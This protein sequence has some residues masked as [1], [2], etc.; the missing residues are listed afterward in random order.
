LR[1]EQLDRPLGLWTR[2]PRFSWQIASSTRG[3]V[4]RAYELE[5]RSVRTPE[6]VMRTGRIESRDSVLVAFDGFEADSATEYRWRVR[7]WV[8][9]ADEPT[10]WAGSTFE[11]ALLRAED[12]RARWIQ[13]RQTPVR[14]DGAA[15]FEELF[16]LRIDSPPEDRLLPAPYVRQR[17]RLDGTPVRARLAATA[18]GIYEAQINGAP[19]SDE[20]FAPGVESYDIHLSFQTYDVTDHVV[21]GDNVLGVVLS[22]G[23]FAGRVGIL[24]SSRGYGDTLK[25]LWQL[26]VDYADGRRATIVSDGTAVS[27]TDG[28][29][30]YADLAVGE[31]YD[32]RIAWDGWSTVAFDDSRWM[33]V[34][35]V[36]VDQPLVPFVGEPVR[37]VGEVPATQILHTPAGDTVVDFG[38]V[39]AGRVRFRVRGERGRIVRL[40][41]AEVRD[42]HGEYFQNIVGPNKDQTDVYVLSGHPDGE[43][44]EPSF[45]FHGFRYVR[46]TGFPESVTADDFT[47]VV[48]SSDLP[49]IGR[50]ETSDERLNRLHANV[51]WSQRANFL[52]IP[53]DCPQRERYGWTGDLQ[54]FA[55]AAATNMAVGPF[56]S[57]WLRIVR[58][59]QLPD[60]RIMNISPSPPQLDHLMDGPAPSYDDPI[61]LLASSAGWGDVIAIAPLVLYQHFADRRVLA[62][63]Y[64]AMQAWAQYQIDSASSGLPP[65]LTGAVL[66]P[67]QRGRQRFLWNNEPNFGDWLAPSTLKGPEASQMTAPRR[68]GEV[69][70]SLYHAHLMDL[71]AEIATILGHSHDATR[72]ALRAAGA[73]EAFAA[74]YIDADGRIPGGL[75]GPY[76]VALAFGFVP[77]DRKADVVARLVE[78]IHDAGDHLD[79]GFL[80]VPFLLDVLWDNGHRD[81]ARTLLFQD[82]APS[83][84]YQVARGA[85]T[86]WEGWEAIAPDGTVTDLSFNHYA[87]GCVDDWLYRRI[88]GI[89]LE[90]P[91]YRESR[92]EPDVVG[93]LTR[94]SAA[95]QTPYG[96]LAARWIRT[97]A[98][99]VELVVTVPPNATSAIHLPETARDILVDGRPAGG[100]SPGVI[101]V[102]SGEV[103]VTFGLSAP[104]D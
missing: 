62:E 51:L 77:D 2:H 31:R 83:W 53:T 19:V 27:S 33:P 49:V 67:E 96:A 94:V 15:S 65:R 24:G 87:F 41:H 89:Q 54:I 99:Q 75:Q 34:A 25:V 88:A 37:R 5:I 70:G 17:F 28:P 45:T 59:D 79:T 84:L 29:I 82:T 56:L 85:T 73:R 69:I 93:P 21:A 8:D 72:Y 66:S 52:S 71:M 40:E 55:A 14:A 100:G 42:Q 23:W 46:I 48:T 101:P 57:R 39:I 76:V 80:S 22:D 68:T 36:D 13:P 32:A 47:A 30:R 78:L 6:Q 63:N 44:W 3:V 98:G 12:W 95:V 58:D 81:L 18:H 35:E 4:Q 104:V 102:G 91:G 20:L 74:E 10:A 11:T 61:M 90:G 60:G 16:T 26:D 86:M 7:C 38:Q 43:S 9:A 92:I 64:A 103:T 50:F 1:V 97:D